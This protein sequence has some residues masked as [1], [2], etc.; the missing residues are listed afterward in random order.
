MSILWGLFETF[1]DF[2][3]IS[4]EPQHC[5][6]IP[7]LGLITLYKHDVR[8]FFWGGIVINKYWRFY[9]TS[10]VPGHSPNWL[11]VS[12]HCCAMK[13]C[14]ELGRVLNNTQF[15]DVYAD[16]LICPRNR[17]FA[18]QIIFFH[19][20]Q[21]A[22]IGWLLWSSYTAQFRPAVF[23]PTQL[24]NKLSYSTRRPVT[25]ITEWIFKVRRNDSRDSS[26]LLRTDNIPKMSPWQRQAKRSKSWKMNQL[27]KPDPSRTR[28][29]LIRS[30][31]RYPL[32]DERSCR[33]TEIR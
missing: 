6:K 14:R 18:S 26:P 11:K 31:A 13:L 1:L 28:D 19:L 3:C 24:L 23:A 8:V 2:L 30:H 5:D 15:T 16:T 12:Q 10:Y 17:F 4:V 9:T 29:F 7:Q 25:G 33:S 32:S 22:R 21:W 20:R 27:F